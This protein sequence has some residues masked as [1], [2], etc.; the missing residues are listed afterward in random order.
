MGCGCEEKLGKEEVFDSFESNVQEDIS[1]DKAK[2]QE[3]EAEK[4]RAAEGE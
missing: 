4:D 2:A 3:A 1:V